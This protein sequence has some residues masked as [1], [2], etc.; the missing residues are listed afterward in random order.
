MTELLT[1]AI[2]KLQA[3]P[4]DEQDAI[5]TIL[6]EELEDEREWDES[7]SQSPGLL[8]QLAATAMAEHQAGETQELN[9]ETL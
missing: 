1:L 5:A 3:L 4:P 7:F 9:P 8:A 2:A 6:L